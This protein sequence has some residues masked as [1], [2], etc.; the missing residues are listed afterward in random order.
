MRL[1]VVL[2]KQNQTSVFQD[3][4]SWAVS[5]KQIRFKGKKKATSS[6]MHSLDPSRGSGSRLSFH[7][8]LK[9]HVRNAMLF[10]F[11]L[12]HS[13]KVIFFEKGRKDREIT[14]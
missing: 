6:E 14:L 4:A 3:A 10:F 7:V 2:W 1:L 12:T 5:P 8:A 13:Q 9:S 11:F